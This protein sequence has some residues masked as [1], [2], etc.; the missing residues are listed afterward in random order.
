MTA[1]GAPTPIKMLS[2]AFR[3][4]LPYANLGYQ[5]VI[6]V[7]GG[8]LLGWW[9]DGKAGSEPLFMIIGALIGA[10]AGIFLVVRTVTELDRWNK[11]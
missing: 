4:Y 7:G 8:F 11:K 5:L 3:Q 2:D 1:K 10:G 9:I 6:A